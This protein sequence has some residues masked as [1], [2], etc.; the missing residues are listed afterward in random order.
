M[1]EYTLGVENVTI[2]FDQEVGKF[3]SLLV[4]K[5]ELS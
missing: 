4:E 2:I 5:E 1:V 3:K